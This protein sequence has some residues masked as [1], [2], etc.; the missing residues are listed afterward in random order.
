MFNPKERLFFRLL[1]DALPHHVV[2]A[3]MPLI[4]FC[5][6]VDL[7]QVRYWHELLGSIYVTFVVCAPNGRVLAALDVDSEHRTPSQRIATIKEE[8]LQACRI[9]YVKC[10]A[11]QFPNVSELQM[12]VPQQGTA[13]RAA[14]PDTVDSVRK[15][16]ATTLAHTVRAR[17]GGQ[18]PGAWADSTLGT[19]SFFAPDSRS[20]DFAVT[21]TMGLVP[22]PQD[23]PTEPMPMPRS[24]PPPSEIQRIDGINLVL[25]PGK[26]SPA[27]DMPT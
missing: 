14:V 5:R 10:R 27:E 24:Y 23:Q 12:L 15:V 25:K 4:R 7:A 17:R 21:D 3:K 26:P 1:C 20:D 11:D 16:H 22:G 19:D 8:V 2:L 18:T 6:P 9:R 13:G